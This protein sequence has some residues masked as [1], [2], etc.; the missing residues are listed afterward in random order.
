MDAVLH[1]VEHLA[2]ADAA[3]PGKDRGREQWLG[4]IVDP[5]RVGLGAEDIIRLALRSFVLRVLLDHR[6]FLDELELALGIAQRL[7]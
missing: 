5:C 2:A 4:S 6:H 3:V 7:A 1:Q